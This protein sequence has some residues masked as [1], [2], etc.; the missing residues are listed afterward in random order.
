MKTRPMAPALLLALTMLATVLAAAQPIDIGS[1]LEL[2][3]DDYLIDAK[4]GAELRLHPPVPR[5]VAIIHNAPWEGNACGYHTVF[6][7]GDMYRMYYRGH[8]Y[9]VQADKFAQA[10]HEVVCYAES[11]DGIHWT[12][13]NLGL[14]D[15]RGSKNNNII[16][17]GT[18][19]H[20]F[21]PFIDTNPDC[22]P[23]ARFKALGG[24]G[25]LYTF[26][27]A[28]GVHWEQ[29]SAEPVITEGAFDSQNVGFWDEVRGH[30][31]AYFRTFTQIGEKRYRSIAMTTSPDLVTWTPPVPLTYPGAPTEQLYTN[32][33]LPYYRA[34]HILLGFPTRYVDR[35]VTEH[36]KTIEPLGLRG[37]VLQSIQ[38]GGTDLTDGVFMTSRDGV[39]FQ[40]WGEAF[41]RPGLQ[42]KGNWLYGNMYQNWGLVETPWDASG[43]GPDSLEG[44]GVPHE[45]SIY[46]SEGTWLNAENRMR[47][48]TLR[49]DGFISMHAPLSGGEC[50]TKPLLFTGKELVINYATSAAGSVRV[51][52]QNADGT[53]VEAFSL[54]D[55]PE[56]YGDTIEQVVSWTSGSDLSGFAGKPIRLRFALKDADLYS[57]RFR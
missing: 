56:M 20:N 51:E 10:Q 47:R 37:I 36:V 21:T 16:W 17:Q 30:Y 42:Q 11:R 44:V 2:M 33:I 23:D 38:R 31:A 29:T 46:V 13:P 28:D 24:G 22:A 48:Y 40:R 52:L 25:A 26:K 15:F 27:S 43:V 34:P 18:G 35:P 49:I 45:L 12:K 50:V 9:I 8:R 41:L 54:A 6:R 53:P 55:C 7:D 14:V 32:G 39:A 19:S 5:E 1:R 4:K 3:V 57:L